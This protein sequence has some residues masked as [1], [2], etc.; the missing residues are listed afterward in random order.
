MLCEQFFHGDVTKK[1]TNFPQNAEKLIF[2]RTFFLL[3]MTNLDI[4]TCFSLTELY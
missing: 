4:V 3:H 2:E 1:E